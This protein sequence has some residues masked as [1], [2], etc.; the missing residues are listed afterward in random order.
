MRLVPFEPHHLRQM[1]VQPA[2]APFIEWMTPEVGEAAAARF[3]FT[4]LDDAGTIIGCAG[5]VETEEGG[6][7]AWATFSTLLTAHAVAV[8]RAVRRGLSLYDGQRIEAHVLTGHTKA[9]AFAERLNFSFVRR[10]AH[11]NG[12]E[13]ML[14]ARER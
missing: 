13:I 9:A 10:M 6:L 11:P 7:G 3:S 2:Q 12:A 5:I 1:E 14:Y 4:G 8:T